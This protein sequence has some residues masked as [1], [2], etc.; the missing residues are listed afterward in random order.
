LPGVDT[1]DRIVPGAWDQLEEDF[2]KHPPLFIADHY[3]DPDSR[4]PV[5]DFPVLARLLAQQYEPVTRTAQG[6]I[7][8]IRPEF[9]PP[10]DL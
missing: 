5:K 10:S 6:I 1:R 2:R 8:R 4:Y 9:R 3:S 7:Y